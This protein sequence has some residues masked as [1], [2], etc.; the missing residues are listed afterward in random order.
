MSIYPAIELYTSDI[1]NFWS[2]KDDN[3]RFITTDSLKVENEHTIEDIETKNINKQSTLYTPDTRYIEYKISTVEIVNNFIK[4]NTIYDT[5]DILLSIKD[6]TYTD[7][8]NSCL[9]KITP[10]YI[11]IAFPMTMRCL[12][13]NFVPTVIK[14]HL[15]KIPKDIEFIDT[16]LLEY[17]PEFIYPRWHNWFRAF[18]LTDIN[19]IKVVILGQ[20]PYHTYSHKNNTPVAMGLSFS[21]IKEEAIPKSL[22]NIFKEIR[23]NFPEQKFEFTHPDLTKWAEQGVLLLNSA[24]TVKKDEP[25]T[26]TKFYAGFM[27]SILSLINEKNRGV[28]YLL[29][30]EKAKFYKTYI[31]SKQ[32]ILETSHPSGF[33]VNRGFF[34]CNHFT[35]VNELLKKQGKKEID[36]QN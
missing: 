33:S 36:W 8:Y 4:Y 6:D 34:G 31:P 23:N 10:T 21:S 16:R 24:L 26:H 13:D 29:W 14:Q 18:H 15:A 9:V 22:G 28:V 27:T 35:K 2:V 25:N 17:E 32:I 12:I 20:D 7:T 30:G 3:I 5:K 1:S 11:Y 19:N